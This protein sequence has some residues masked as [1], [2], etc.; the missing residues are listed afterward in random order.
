MPALRGR[1]RDMDVD[2]IRVVNRA[3]P[4]ADLPGPLWRQLIDD[5]RATPQQPGT[6]QA[7]DVRL[8]GRAATHLSDYGTWK[9]N[10]SPAPQGRVKDTEHERRP[11][12]YGYERAV[13]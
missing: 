4:D 7:R 3:D 13:I 2:D 11:T 8:L 5:D 1:Q 6:D 9:N 12:R 10:R